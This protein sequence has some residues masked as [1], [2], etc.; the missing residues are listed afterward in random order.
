M[1][2][3]GPGTAHD[4]FLGWCCTSPVGPGARATCCLTLAE[5]MEVG[6]TKKKLGKLLEAIWKTMAVNKSDLKTTTSNLWVILCDFCF[7][8]VFHLLHLHSQILY[9]LLCFWFP[10]VLSMLQI[11]GSYPPFGFIHQR[12]CVWEM[13]PKNGPCSWEHPALRSLC[14][15]LWRE[16]SDHITRTAD[17][18]VKDWIGSMLWWKKSG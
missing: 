4:S 3:I 17:K 14:G 1:T 11:N 15:G 12:Y 13:L 16:V 10:F 5:E 9:I 8:F 6:Q 18:T 7:A 2:F